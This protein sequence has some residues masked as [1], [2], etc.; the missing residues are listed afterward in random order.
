MDMHKPVYRSEVFFE[1]IFFTMKIK[2]FT[3]PNGLLTLATT[4][5]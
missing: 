4:V 3:L 2:M 1:F 5:G